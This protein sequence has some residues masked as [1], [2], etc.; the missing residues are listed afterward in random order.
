MNT[1]EVKIAGRIPFKIIPPAERIKEFTYYINDYTE[2][3]AKAEAV[4]CLMC[5]DPPCVQACPAEINIPEFIYSIAT[6]NYRRAAKIVRE[7]NVFGGSCAYLCP[8]ERLCEGV[9]VRKDCDTPLA[10]SMLQRFAYRF[11]EKNGMIFFG[12]EAPKNRRIA[13]IGGGPGGLT[14][15][16]E[17]ARRGYDVT[18]F[19]REDE[20]GGLLL[21]GILPYKYSWDILKNEVEYVRNYQVKLVYNK[22]IKNITELKNMGYDAVFIASG[23]TKP[24]RLGIPGEELEG[25]IY[26]LDFLRQIS[27]W[28]R[29]GTPPPDVRGKRVVVIGGG[30]TAI[31]AA[32]SSMRLGAEKVH[33]AYRRSLNEIKAVP[34]SI[35]QSQEEGIEFMFQVAPK[36]IIGKEGK[37]KAIEFMRMQ[38]GALD[39]TGR[40]K[41]IPIEG[42][43]FTM[44]IDIVLVAIGQSVDE[45]FTKS[46]GVKVGRGGLIVVDENMKT[47]VEGVY[48]GG[49]I[50]N[51]GDTV[52]RAIGDA[53]RAAESIDRYLKMRE[54]L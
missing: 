28:L 44:D 52:V 32:I 1:R 37:V 8:V 50:V 46:L 13:V 29:K 18:V 5:L 17:L 41:P 23:V 31:D 54:K 47:S 34:S 38:L 39:E 35:K 22:E 2:E 48:A 16:Y 42:S 19:E 7:S 10:I 4:R 36:R 43:E 20:A 30:D 45:N 51:G 12:R 24:L 15:A 33:I 3:Q 6:G 27:R 53:K 14:A 49:D 40:R 21:H 26:A 11:E 9:C 25:V